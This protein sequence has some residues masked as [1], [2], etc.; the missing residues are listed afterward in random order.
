MRWLLGRDPGDCDGCGAALVRG[1][2][3][4]G[5]CGA[6]VAGAAGPV[7][8]VDETESGPSDRADDGGRGRRVVGGL[9]VLALVGAALVAGWDRAPAAVPLLGTPDGASGLSASGPP[10]DGLRIAWRHDLAED[11]V[12]QS[13][14]VSSNVDVAADG[15]RIAVAGRVVDR[16][17]GRLVRL[18]PWPSAG[19]WLDGDDLVHIDPIS[20]TIE[21]VGPA[22]DGDAGWPV[23][24]LRDVVVLTRDDS[25]T[26]TSPDGRVLATSRHAYVQHLDRVDDDAVVLPV[27]SGNGSAESDIVL[28]DTSDGTEVAQLPADGASQ[29]VDVLGS[30]LLHAATT[31]DLG[32][33]GAGVTWRV[34]VHRPFGVDQIGEGIVTSA[35][36]PRLLGVLGDGTVV[37]GG[38]TG[39]TVSVWLLRPGQRTVDSFM[40]ARSPSVSHGD[41]LGHGSGDITAQAVVVGDLVVM[42]D[43]G[44]DAARAFD[45]AGREVWRVEAD[46]A[47]AIGVGDGLLALLSGESGDGRAR[48]VDG[49]TGE[50]VVTVPPGI[51]PWGGERDVVAAFD[52]H[53][54]VGR[55]MGWTG[56]IE[57]GLASTL[58][59]GEEQGRAVPAADVFAG[60]LP[61]GEVLR[62][63]WFLHGVTTGPQ[64]EPTPVITQGSNREGLDVLGP[65]GA[66]ST[67][68][69]GPLPG[70]EVAGHRAQVVGVSATHVV[71][72]RQS[73]E[74][75]TT[76]SHVIERETGT[77]AVLDG[78]EVFGLFGD[79]LL[80]ADVE[81][82]MVVG[83]AEIVGVDV[84]D[85]SELW[86]RP[87]VIDVIFGDHLLV[88]D[89]AMLAIGRQDVRL[90][91]LRTGERRWEHR[92]S[93][94]LWP[95]AS[96]L[97]PET[98]VVS[99]TD[100]Q[101]V[102]LDRTD[103]S[104]VW[105]TA[106]STPIT[107]M[108]GAG[109]HVVVGTVDGLVVHLDRDGAEVQ[110]VA[111]STDAVTSVAAVGETVVA[112]AGDV[113]TGLRADGDGIVE[114]DE[115]DLP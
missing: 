15:E 109:S 103:G 111:V 44:A 26:L 93:E 88:D 61:E 40:T 110:R 100:G 50:D 107:T 8:A 17:T 112:V 48:V 35:M 68:D 10:P 78:L 20:G 37:V 25:V 43:G 104:E 95:M 1:G 65:D 46:G 36:A 77:V 27:R 9:V 60:H 38:R 28:L 115:V 11:G 97:G 42:L 92:P 114:Q 21:R 96:V 49:A 39:A 2:S 86:R 58:W 89:R 13:Y 33:P 108:T 5:A 74:D 72:V 83:V 34:R 63:D 73:F 47:A 70:T 94:V 52:G 54:A 66:F 84:T 106:L 69:L 75:G 23:A 41:P 85:G 62:Q 64:G 14:T 79:V 55:D 98:V 59:L 31:S 67:V 29:V 82:G 7:D 24:M 81:P 113:V 71:V 18:D 4:C 56:N 99:T 87:D 45:T 3:W 30:T 51:S 91:D 19:L 22:P 105:R 80:G 32:A 57:L 12:L 16:S 101:V 6:A 53:L 90:V 76:T 102:A